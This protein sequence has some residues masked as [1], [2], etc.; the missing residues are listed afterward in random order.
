MK[1]VLFYVPFIFTLAIF[2]FFGKSQGEFFGLNIAFGYGGGGGGG[3]GITVIP[4]VLGVPPVTVVGGNTKIDRN[5]TLL[6]NV[7]NAAMVAVSDK[8]NFADASWKSYSVNENFTLSEGYGVKTLFVKFRSNS[9]G[10]TANQTVTIS[11][12]E[13]VGSATTPPPAQSVSSSPSSTTTVSTFTIK[14]R[15]NLTPNQRQGITNLVN[16]GRLFSKA[17]ARNYAYAIGEK[18]WQQFVGTNP[19]TMTAAGGGYKFTRV[20]GIGAVGNDVRALQQILKDLGY[21]KHPSITG[22]FGSV[23]K[24]AVIQ[25]QSDRNLKPSTGYIGLATI[26]ALNAE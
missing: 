13:G 24:A 15:S 22:Y 26:S 19:K 10:E 17:D 9:G 18:N 5:I 21:F 3:G 23:T 14:F 2:G 6:F 25:Y 1:K 8:A 16:S 7:E 11:Y 20:F 4:P 12:V